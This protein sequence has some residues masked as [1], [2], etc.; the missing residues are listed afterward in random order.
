MKTLLALVLLAAGSLP[1]DGQ[2]VNIQLKVL[3]RETIQHRLE[4]VSREISDRRATL[5]SLFEEVGCRDERLT[6][7]KV[8]GSKFPNLIC[9]MPGADPDAGVIVV[10]GH[11]DLI[12]KGMGA[13]DDWSGVVLLPSLYQSLAALPR[14]HTFVFVGFAAEERGLFGSTEYVHHLSKPR[15]AGIRAMVNLEC[16]GTSP[17]KVWASR[18]DQRL[19]ARLVNVASSMDLEIRA[20]NVDRVG[21]DDSHPFLS[22]RIPVIT[23]HSITQETFGFLHSPRDQLNAIDAKNYYQAYLLA[24]TFL[25]YLDAQPR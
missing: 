14:R 1:A 18:A 7:Q 4:T 24:S 9:T 20:S 8:S 5:V 21:D 23:L 15:K 16:L 2:S 17:P 13:V 6:S 11:F 3:P 10:G 12:D 22:A 19:L 25:A